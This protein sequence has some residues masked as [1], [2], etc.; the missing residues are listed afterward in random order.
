M[1]LNTECYEHC[2][3][4][5]DAYRAAGTEFVAHGRTNSV[6]PNELDEDSERELIRDV[7]ETMIRSTRASP[8]AAG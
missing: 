5:V 4:L 3:Q 2:P 7:F 8:P 1:L 6:H